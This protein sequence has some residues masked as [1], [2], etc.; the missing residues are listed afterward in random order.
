M[1]VEIM[2]FGFANFANFDSTTRELLI[3]NLKIYL[4]QSLFNFFKEEM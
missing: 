2:R 3:M 4:L 1:I